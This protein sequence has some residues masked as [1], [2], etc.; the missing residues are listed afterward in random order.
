MLH[1]LR[2]SYVFKHWMGTL[3]LGSILV[4]ISPGFNPLN[5]PGISQTILFSLLF[6]Y[7]SAVYSIPTLICYT[8]AFSWLKSNT[9]NTNWIKMTLILITL[10]G[11]A[12]TMAL[13]MGSMEW[14]IY[15]S[16]AAIVTG[17]S[18]KI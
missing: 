10:A 13:T 4:T 3:L 7:Y 17:I 6:L 15:Y 8:L 12:M 18:F 16:I 2:W 1:S 14:A 11:I 9:L 5:S